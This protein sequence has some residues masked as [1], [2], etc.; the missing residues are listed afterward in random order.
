LTINQVKE[1][2]SFS[3]TMSVEYNQQTFTMQEDAS[4][5]GKNYWATLVLSGQAVST[6]NNGALPTSLALG[7]SATGTL[8]LYLTQDPNSRDKDV[9]ATLQ[10]LT[11]HGAASTPELDPSSGAGALSLVLGGIGVVLGRRRRS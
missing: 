8:T 3:T 4:T 9:V 10:T 5:S 2:S 1:T 6:A 7:G 11:P